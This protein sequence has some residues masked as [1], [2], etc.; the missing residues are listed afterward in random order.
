MKIAQ[1]HQARDRICQALGANLNALSANIMISVDC[2]FQLIR[3]DSISKI[4]V[5]NRT[6]LIFILTFLDYQIFFEKFKCVVIIHVENSEE[7]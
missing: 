1:G 4:Y 5:L 2:S 3:T 6:H 7:G